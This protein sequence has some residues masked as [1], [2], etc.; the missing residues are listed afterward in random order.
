M[1]RSSAPDMER[2]GNCGL[3]LFMATDREML[4]ERSPDLSGPAAVCQIAGFLVSRPG[5]MFHSRKA[6]FPPLWL[7]SGFLRDMPG[8]NGSSLDKK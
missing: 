8:W 1:L 5:L 6:I 7:F 4:V 3:D 2:R